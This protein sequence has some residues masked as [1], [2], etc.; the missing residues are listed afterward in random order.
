MIPA[1]ATMTKLDS[2]ARERAGC[3]G[4]RGGGQRLLLP[5]EAGVELVHVE[6]AVEAEVLRVRAQEALDVCLA[7][8]DLE[9]LFLERPQVLRADLGVR[10]YPGELETLAQPGF[11]QAVAD[12]EHGEPRIV[13]PGT[14]RPTA[15]PA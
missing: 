14:C 15:K 10:F 3:L 7:G 8:Q 4:G 1:R 11:T 12:L 13:A 9:A 5:R 2:T 6:L